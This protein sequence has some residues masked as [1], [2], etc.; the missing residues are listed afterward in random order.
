MSR[1]T[2]L[3]LRFAC[4]LTFAILLALLL[5][6]HFHLETPRWSVMTAALVTAGPAFVAGGEPFAGAIRHRGWLRIVGTCIGCVAGVAIVI[7]FA[8]A[9]VLMLMVCCIWAG[10]CTWLSSLV[11]IENSYSWGLAGYTT[12]I[13]V[14]TVSGNV[15]QAPQFAV[16]RCSEII[17][18][19]LCAVLADLLF[20]PRS[21]KQDIDRL[22][23]KLLVEHF[24]LMQRTLQGITWKEIDPLW[25]TLVKDTTALE[26]MRNYLLMESVRWKRAHR[27][28]VA[29]QSLSLDLITLSCETQQ[30]STASVFGPIQSQFTTPVESLAEVRQRMKLLRQVL[31]ETPSDNI[32]R[33]F[34]SWVKTMTQGLLLTKGIHTHS[35][36]SA[37]EEPILDN[38]LIV[39]PV[40][41]EG[42]HA[43][44]NGLR[45]CIATGLGCLLWLWTGWSAGSGM[46]IFIAIVTALAMRAPNP[47]MVAL[48]FFLGAV[49]ALPLGTLYFLLIM[50]STQQ[51]FLLLCI[52]LG[53][54]AFVVGLEVQKRRLGSLGTLVSTLNIIVLSN[55]MSFNMSLFIDNALGQ[56][57]GTSVSMLVL[58][59]VRDNSRER[60]GRTLLNRFVASAVSALTTQ[61]TRRKENHLPALYQQLNQLVAMFPQDSAKYHLALQLIVAQQHLQAADIPANADLSAFHKEIRYT[62]SKLSSTGSAIKRAHYF[63]RLLQEIAIYQQKLI[64][65]QASEESQREVQHLVTMLQQYQHAL[66]K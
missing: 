48:D 41:S 33:T 24:N 18:G 13:T 64:T 52:S 37:Q 39:K 7:L 1:L 10:F 27:R 65:Y 14:V 38:E 4:K 66:V 57:I 54:L 42:Y 2:F 63:A 35:S 25:Q 9:P 29:L 12:L 22:V 56:I 6:F 44:I 34:G 62:A 26:G 58:V 23:S 5:G 32:S 46:M 53:I 36:I 60:T 20:S 31:A 47:H 17:L 49:Y 55:P 3:R 11:K 59:L 51:S 21:I 8:R 15:L 19:L 45:T 50:P 40:S 61:V 30:V 16:E 28:L 43:L